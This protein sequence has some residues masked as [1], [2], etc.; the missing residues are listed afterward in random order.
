MINAYIIQ[1]RKLKKVK[2]KLQ[3]QSQVMYKYYTVKAQKI[4]NISQI[5]GKE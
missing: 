5:I 4:M 2:D 1:K 3:N